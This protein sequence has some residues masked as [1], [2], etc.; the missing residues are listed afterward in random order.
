MGW[1]HVVAASVAAGG[2]IDVRAVAA[3][4][5]VT[6]RAI[7][8]R[9]T[10]EGWE[11]PFP[12][13][14]AVAGTR[15]DGRAWACAAVLH[16]T[17]GTGD[18]ARDL[19]AITR[20][21]ALALLGVTRSYPT[22]SEVVIP[23]HRVLTPHP[24]LT[25]V[26]SRRLRTEDVAEQDGV[27]VVVGPALLGD[28]A[29]V[30]DQVGLRRAAIDLAHAGVVDLDALPA[31]LAAHPPFPGKPRLR[32]VAADLLGA[33]RTDSPF[34]YEVRTRLADEGIPLD[35]GQVPLP[36]PQR[37][38]LDLGILAI[39]FGIELHGFGFHAHRRD[40]ERD[41]ARANA[42]ALLGDGWKV[43]HATWSVLGDGW[44]R[45]VDDVRQAITSQ[46]QRHLGVAWPTAAHLRR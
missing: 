19:A 16:A 24:R 37:L 40:L 9:A 2:P 13:V 20:G 36:G 31:F 27:P 45:F 15:M 35:R 30:R 43:L 39:R 1:E 6:P 34:E 33:G 44:G 22:R 42:V 12:Y 46:A 14:V 18:P 10:R 41:T 38:H 21:S 28:L 29:A 32:Q 17:G 8:R 25:V 3:T 5:G 4:C 7:L 23:A 26:R 11:R